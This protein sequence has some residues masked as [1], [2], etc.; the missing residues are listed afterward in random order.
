MN[1]RMRA[2]GL[3]AAGIRAGETVTP[4]PAPEL[5]EDTTEVLGD[6]GYTEQ[7]IQDLLDQGAVVQYRAT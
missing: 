2:N 5:G 7:Q 6:L 1:V 4:G 3:V